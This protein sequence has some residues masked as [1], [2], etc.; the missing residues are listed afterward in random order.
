[1]SKKFFASVPLFLSPINCLL[2]YHY[3]VHVFIHVLSISIVEATPPQ[4]ITE[5][6]TSSEMC[7][8]LGSF[9][10][11]SFASVK[12]FL[13]LITYHMLY[14][15]V[16]FQLHF[17]LCSVNDFIFILNSSSK[18]IIS[19]N[20]RGAVSSCIPFNK[21]YLPSRPFD[22]FRNCCR[23]LCKHYL[24]HPIVMTRRLFPQNT[25]NMKL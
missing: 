15:H 11:S 22:I 12:L 3:I 4:L 14:F 21:G 10:E 24:F 8:F 9:F 6:T 20:N 7:L 18:R 2:L 23:H 13:Y 19:N 1:M 5:A 25:S 17:I 16:H